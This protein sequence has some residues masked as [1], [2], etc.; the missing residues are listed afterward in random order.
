MH[1]VRPE[2]AYSTIQTAPCTFWGTLFQFT[3]RPSRSLSQQPTKSIWILG[4]ME[5]ASSVI[6]R[7]TGTVFMQPLCPSILRLCLCPCLGGCLAAFL[8]VCFSAPPQHAIDLCPAVARARLKQ[9]W[10]ATNPQPK[11]CI[12]QAIYHAQ[13]PTSSCILQWAH[14]RLLG[15][16]VTQW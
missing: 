4:G 16:H 11:Y 10:H 12:V 6:S 5:R 15:A 9:P 1:C 8:C 2:P 14:Q 3:R 13:D 7:T